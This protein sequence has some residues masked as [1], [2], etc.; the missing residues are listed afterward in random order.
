MSDN[1]PA[2]PSDHRYTYNELVQQAAWSSHLV[3][4][5]HRREIAAENGEPPPVLEEAVARHD[6]DR[7][8][9]MMDLFIN[10][11]FIVRGA[12]GKYEAKFL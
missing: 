4:M 9:H 8:I 5:S 2:R 10:L 12:D 6:I 7:G 1:Q 11:G 3:F